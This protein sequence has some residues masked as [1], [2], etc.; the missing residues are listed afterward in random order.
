M[1]IAPRVIATMS[2]VVRTEARTIFIRL[3]QHSE[4]AGRR[5]AQ[6]NENQNAGMGVKQEFRGAVQ[7]VRSSAQ[8][9][10]IV[11]D[12]DRIARIRGIVLDAGGLA[13]DETFETELPFEAGDVLRGVVGDAGNRVTVSDEVP[14]SQ[15]NDRAR[16]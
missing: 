1:N 12:E 10:P 2:T 6:L 8:A 15:I 4:A 3:T 16:T 5:I 14:G 7:T 11:G 9:R 13:G